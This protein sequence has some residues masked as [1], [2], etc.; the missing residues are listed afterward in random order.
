MISLLATYI[1]Y[2]VASYLFQLVCTC[3]QVA[4]SLPWFPC[5][6]EEGTYSFM[7]I[8]VLLLVI[9][10]NLF[11]IPLYR[12]K[13]AIW[14]AISKQ[15]RSRTQQAIAALNMLLEEGERFARFDG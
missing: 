15:C 11:T 6:V 5:R 3:P 9:A 4:N 2:S 8:L 1:F 13:S 7:L 10:T 14:Y 12:L